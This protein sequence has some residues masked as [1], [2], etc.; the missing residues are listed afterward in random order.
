VGGSVLFKVP[1][2]MCTQHPD[3]TVRVGVEGEVFEAV[4]SFM[5]YGCDEVMADYEGKLTPYTQPASI[6]VEASRHGL[7]LGE[8]VLGHP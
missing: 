5:V 6:V 4:Q 7:A 1:M 2:L 3:S 8:E